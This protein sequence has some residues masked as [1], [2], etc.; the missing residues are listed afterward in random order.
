MTVG[1]TQGCAEHNSNGGGLAGWFHEGGQGTLEK[2]KDKKR[3]GLK[4]RMRVPHQDRRRRRKQEIK[5]W[6]TGGG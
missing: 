5:H 2:P 3:G 1:R 6:T 4:K